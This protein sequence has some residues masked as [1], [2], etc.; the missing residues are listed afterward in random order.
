MMGREYKQ[1]SAVAVVVQQ[2]DAVLSPPSRTL[3]SSARQGRVNHRGMYG[4]A[5]FLRH[6]HLVRVV[7][8]ASD[9][10]ADSVSAA[11]HASET[12]ERARGRPPRNRRE[13]RE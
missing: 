13:A 11:V 6:G 2:M 5:A 8:P 1:L 4:P 7:V 3:S 12:C 10:E 9:G